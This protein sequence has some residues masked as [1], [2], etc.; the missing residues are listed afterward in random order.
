VDTC[1]CGDYHFTIDRSEKD[2]L[3]H[4]PG[5]G[6]TQYEE[7]GMARRPT[8]SRVARKAWALAHVRAEPVEGVRPDRIAGQDFCSAAIKFS[9]LDNFISEHKL[10]TGPIFPFDVRTDFVKVTDSTVMVP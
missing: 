1:Q 8:A 2:A 4:V 6:Q 7:M 3:L 10:M 5:A 9:D